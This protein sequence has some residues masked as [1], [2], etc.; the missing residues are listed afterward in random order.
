[1]N[2]ER[3][4][5]PAAC[6]AL[7]LAA[8]S[9]L[10]QVIDGSRDGNYGA[11]LTTQG[12]RVID[13]LVAGPVSGAAQTNNSNIAGL[14][15]YLGGDFDGPPEDVL[16]GIE[17]VIPV[18]E[19]D[20]DGSSPIDIVGF[21]NGQSHDFMSNQIIGGLANAEFPAPGNPGEPRNVDFQDTLQFPGD[22]FR[23]IAAGTPGG[24]EAIDGIASA[25]YPGPSWVQDVP[26]GFGN[27]TN[28][29]QFAAGG[30]EFNA[31]RA[32]R[33]DNGTPGVPGDD[34]VYVHISGNLQ[35]NFNKIDIFFDVKAGGQNRLRNDNADVDFNGL[36]RMGSTAPT[37]GLLF[38]VDFEADY[39]L[40]LTNGIGGGGQA[41]IFGSAAVIFT[42]GDP[43]TGTPEQAG[44]FVAG[45][46][47]ASGPYTGAGPNGGDITF[48][49]D[50][51]N[52]L[53][54]SSP[55]GGTGGD[56]PNQVPGPEA[57]QTGVEFV[58]N[59]EE[60][61]YDD[62]GQIGIAGFLMFSGWDFFSN[63]VIGGLP[64]DTNS[65]GSP[66]SDKSFNDSD[67]EGIPGNQFVTLS[68]PANPSTVLP[69]L[70]GQREASYGPA[71]WVNSNST[72]FGNN[73]DAG[74]DDATGSE[75]CAVY[76]QVVEDAEGDRQLYVFIAGNV[77]QFHR[78]VTFY[79][80]KA[81]GQNPLR[82][83]NP[84]IDFNGLN[85]MEG[86][87]F[88]GAFVPDFCVGY[89]L[90][91]NETTLQVEHYLDAAEL[92]TDGSES[93]TPVG[94]RL[95][96]GAKTAAPLSGEIALTQGFGDNSLGGGAQKFDANGSEL[97]AVYARIGTV[98]NPFVGPVPSLFL[99][100]TGNLEPNGN[101]LEIFFD[102]IPG[103]GQNTLIYDD[104]ENPNGY[105]GNPIIE[106]PEGGQSA[107]LNRMGGDFP[108]FLLD[109]NGDPVLD[110]FGEP[111]IVE[112]LPGL[113]FDSGF[114]A[115]HWLSVELFGYNPSVPSVTVQAL[116][117]RLR[118]AQSPGDA[119][120]GRFVGSAEIFTGAD[121]SFLNGT[122]GGFESI[123]AFV[124]NSNIAGV[125]GGEDPAIA[126]ADINGPAA[127]VTTGIEV[128]IPLEDLNWDGQSDIKIQAFING[129]N[130][131]FVSNQHLQ[132]VC[133][134]DLGEPRLVN[135]N[136]FDGVQFLELDRLPASSNFQNLS[137]RPDDCEAAIE[138][139][140]DLNGDNEVNSD[141]LGILLSAFGGGAAGDLDGDGDTDSDDLGILLSAFGDVCG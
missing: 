122:L 58:I 92:L 106:F 5:V 37:N 19:L 111:I 135:F 35:T 108:I 2:M 98:N 83:D 84:D 140:G 114:N 65:L 69:A 96:G 100:L 128:A 81:G 138:C 36:N 115:D 109:E 105:Q 127:S 82:G 93:Q 8:G 9:S 28:P 89:H 48:L 62:N 3:A 121:G 95:D 110:E 52:V 112:T 56:V 70:N 132:F 34:L 22:Q 71:L 77:G 80:L 137:A 44:N 53:G 104:P 16:T 13:I 12:A 4:I 90:G 117:A 85:N 15:A 47:T 102:T 120:D 67:P 6:A 66:A 113:T 86:F 30:S 79:D 42:D 59:L 99:M 60:A 134:F 61:G 129:I 33:D 131:D 126:F 17:F 68:V 88:D 32:Y 107:A 26:T 119:G 139:P 116:F 94:G 39:Y 74:P 46:V 87:A 24:P 64:A 45:G 40:T 1:M 41:E 29:D 25:N 76:A 91:F 54:V 10:G 23:S 78:L 38:D 21:I 11:A 49:I 14:G 118:G 57:V 72:S 18:A 125:P 136:D 43:N 73:T 130:H 124:D 101:K 133:S 20:W 51:S 141:D 123:R 103:N 31:L 7:L 75:I 97:A 50:N 27:N 63:Q 55:G